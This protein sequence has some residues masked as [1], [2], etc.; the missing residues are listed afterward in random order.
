MISAEFHLAREALTEGTTRSIYEKLYRIRFNEYRIQYNAPRG[1]EELCV[2]PDCNSQVSVLP[3]LC[4]LLDRSSLSHGHT[5][6]QA[7]Y[8]NRFVGV[9]KAIRDGEKCV[10]ETLREVLCEV[11]TA[12][13][14]PEK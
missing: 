10:V 7:L 14:L 1:K 13:R 2:V 8:L 11:C 5:S 12:W 9:S 3:G 4:I 6:A